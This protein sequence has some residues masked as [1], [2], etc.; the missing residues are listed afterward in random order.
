MLYAPSATIWRT[1]SAIPVSAGTLV[2]SMTVF[3]APSAT[4]R[5]EQVRGLRSFPASAWWTSTPMW[6]RRTADSQFP[7]RGLRILAAWSVTVMRMRERA[8]RPQ[9]RC[10]DVHES[11]V[12]P[13]VLLSQIFRGSMFDQRVQTMQFQRIQFALLVFVQSVELLSHKPHPILLGDLTVLVRLHQK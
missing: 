6:L 12:S 10:A 7:I 2:I 1:S 4:L 9:D 13:E 8:S 5:T 11:R 3:P